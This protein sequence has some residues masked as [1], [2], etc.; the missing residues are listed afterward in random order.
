[1]RKLL[2]LACVAACAFSTGGCV[3]LIGAAAGGVGV[4]AASKDTIQ[5]ETD[6]SSERLWDSAMM[7]IKYRGTI[8]QQKVDQGSIEALD[9]KTRIW[10]QVDRITQAT[11]RL[12]VAARSYKMPN[13]DVAQS[14]YTKIIEQARPSQQ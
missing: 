6:I 9:G 1:M 11:S 10:V 2:V 5:G 4:Y 13:L 8:T 7:V 14:I 12:K 3:L